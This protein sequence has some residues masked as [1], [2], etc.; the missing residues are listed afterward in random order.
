MPGSTKNFY[1]DLPTSSLSISEVLRQN[2]FAAIPADW[3]VVIADVK[4]STSAVDA[5]N[6]NDV[7]LVAA[8]CLVAALNITRKAG[9][10]IPFFFT[11]DGGTVVVPE[12][13]LQE[14]IAGLQIH[15]ENTRQNFGLDLHIGSLSLQEIWA[16]GHA[17]NVAK[18]NSGNNLTRAIVTG[19]GL[20]YAEQVVKQSQG[21]T[22]APVNYA[23]LDMEGL[24]CRWDKIKP[25]LKENEVVCY[26]IVAQKAVEQPMVYADVLQKMDDILGTHDKRNPLSLD[27]LRLLL[28]V[29]KMRREMMARFGKWNRTYL[30]V[31]LLK[32]FFGSLYFKY[33]WRVND[34]R[35]HD[36][37]TQVIDNADIL[38]I[39]GR[40]NSIVSA[41]SEKRKKFVQYLQQMEDAGKLLFGH[42]VRR[43]SVMTC[44]IE[45]RKEKHL[46]FVDG[47][48][49]GYTEAAKELKRKFKQ[50]GVE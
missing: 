6:H 36:Y 28:N 34:Q 43:E 41:T 46:H 37:L 30:I 31:N 20:Q 39:D 8:G 16:A 4:N 14:I 23:E 21:Q 33:N 22:K 40:I 35:G 45:S 32:T 9:I 24:E 5:G 1:R 47:A 18:V 7:N 44:Y 11:G 27:R 42:C 12:A 2:K 19:S 3:H 25:P 48:D 50:L 15:N 26:L 17:I 13:I 29:N 38:T 10:E 49:G